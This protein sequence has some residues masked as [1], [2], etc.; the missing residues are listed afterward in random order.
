MTTA[1]KLYSRNNQKLYHLLGEHQ[2]FGSFSV[3]RIFMRDG[4]N[5]SFM[6]WPN[7]SPCIIGN[8]F[9]LN[10]FNRKGRGGNRGL[11]RSGQGGGSMGDYAAKLSQLLRFCYADKIDPIMMN[12]GKFA[13]YIG[14]LRKEISPRNP[15]IKKRTE[16]SISEIGRVWLDFL[17]FVGRI[18]G[19]DDFVSPEGRIRAE[20]KTFEVISRS[21]Q[22]IKKT[23]LTHYSFGHPSRRKSRD[24]ITDEQI[25]LLKET[26]RKSK[27]S[28][29][30][31]ARRSVLIDTMT[32]T[33]ARRSEI[34][35][36]TIDDVKKAKSM[37]TPTLSM[38]TLKRGG[39]VV[40]RQVPV[41]P[42]LLQL[43]D[44]FIEKQRRAVMK[45]VYKGGK[46]HRFLFV[47]E[48][49]GKPLS[50]KTIYN[51]IRNLKCTSGIQSQICPHMFRHRFITEYF[52]DFIKQHQI[53]NA[54]EFRQSL[55]TNMAL[56]KQEVT[57][58]TGHLAPS[59]IDDYLHLALARLNDYSAAITSIYVKR[60][61]DG[62]F[63]REKELHQRLQE[64]MPVDDYLAELKVLR[65]FYEKDLA[66]AEHRGD[67]TASQSAQT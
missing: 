26:S 36:L 2:T 31:K 40:I 27:D 3:D 62:Y 33:G 21:G 57:Q 58:W 49:T 28:N 45:K 52:I 66:V 23:Y 37:K 56:F 30:V 32:D 47:S 48:T 55:L 18:H 46:D 17:G 64:G 41:T 24:P 5:M 12:D 9:M 16:D 19:Y 60:A 22:K 10:L 51:E 42:T 25:L 34:A 7:G 44:T 38:T 63:M 53:N 54:D 59:S 29:I 15:A 61:M 35:N 4:T 8:L 14:E 43:L 13:D 20:T 67:S 50:S 65:S 1:N 11:S 6:T 39:E